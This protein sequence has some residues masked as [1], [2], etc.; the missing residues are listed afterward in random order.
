MGNGLIIAIGCAMAALLYGAFSIK[1]ILSL[2]P[3]NERMREIATAIQ[4]GASAYLNRQYTTISI[5]GVILLVAIFA[6][7]GMETAVGFALGAFLSGIAGYIGMNVSVRANVRTAEAA[8]D[9]LNAALDVAF[10][11][12]AITG[13]L[14]VGLGLLGVAGYYAVLTVGMGTSASDA[15]HALVGL[16]FGSSLISIFARLGGGSSPRVQT[17]VLI[18]SVRLRPGFLKMTHAILR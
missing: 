13:M 6:A 11:G 7:L 1:W 2:S 8:R 4:E 12:G 9:G 10:K 5:V 3:G 15:T 14:V 17:W 16:A 18:W